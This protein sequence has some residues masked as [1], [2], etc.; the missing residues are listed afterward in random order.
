MSH[1]LT[2]SVLT[3]NTVARAADVNSRFNGVVAAFDKLPDPIYISED[4]ITYSTDTGVANAYVATPIIPITAYNAGLRVR[5]KA[6]V[7][8]TGAATLN[9]SGLG[10]KPIVRADGTTLTNG[11]I[12]AGQILDLTY[13]GVSFRLAMAFAVMTAA[14]VAA[15][16]VEAGGV[17][18]NLTFTGNLTVT[19]TVNGDFKLYAPGG[20]SFGIGSTTTL[21]SGAATGSNNTVFGAAAG[22]VFTTAYRDTAV[23]SNAL[24]AAT[25]GHQNTAVG[26]HCMVSA[27]P[28]NSTAI[29]AFSLSNATGTFNTALGNLAGPD[30]TTGGYNTLVGNTAGDGITTG[31][32]NTI[33]GARVPTLA[34][35]T[36][37]NVILADGEGT[38]RFH[39]DGVNIILNGP[40]AARSL[41]LTAARTL[42]NADNGRFLSTTANVTV[43]ASVFVVGDRVRVY[44]NS[45]AATSIVQGT[46]VT[47]RLAGTATTGTRT[48]AARGIS[49]IT[50]I[51]ATE[52]VVSGTGVT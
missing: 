30:L 41:E 49:E 23:G 40:V 46:G 31:S 35:G 29:G 1:Y 7:G 15:K 17:T 43:P 5:L 12:V 33:V 39:W 4:R 20:G 14:G 16:L 21:A 9:V 13:D 38:I 8:N 10:V 28:E 25:T 51:S 36:A 37:R 26:F 52:A 2:Y 34:A 27:N 45:A 19:G 24:G 6:L 47:L 18:G 42:V 3:A 22:A 11:D 48:L 44:N 32:H 50:F